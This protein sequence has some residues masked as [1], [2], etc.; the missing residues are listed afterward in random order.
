MEK[1][2]SLL[3]SSSGKFPKE[4]NLF[5]AISS[6][7]IVAVGWYLTDKV[8]EPRLRTTAVDGDLDDLPKMESL[9]PLE[10]KGMWT[11]VA[12]MLAGL[13]LVVITA[14][15][16]DSAWRNAEGESQPHSTS[17]CLWFFKPVQPCE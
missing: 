15:P 6:L 17:H 2:S 3:P 13:A 4:K 7:L 14:L 16:A 1:I 9:T 12:V 8:V 5:T 11:A 10:R